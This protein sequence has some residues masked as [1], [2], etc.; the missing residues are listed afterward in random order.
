MRRRRKEKLTRKQR[1]IKNRVKLRTLFLVAITLIFNTYAWF[2]YVHTV[3]GNLRA[4][5]DAWH[6]EFQVDNQVV[7]REF[8]FDIHEY[9]FEFGLPKF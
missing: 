2:L 6:V 3:S 7:E 4:H 1:R 5:V 9:P 8:N